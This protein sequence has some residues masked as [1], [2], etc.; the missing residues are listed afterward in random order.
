L[1]EDFLDASQLEVAGV[2]ANAC[3]VL[4]R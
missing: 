3:R 2:R 4:D 1:L